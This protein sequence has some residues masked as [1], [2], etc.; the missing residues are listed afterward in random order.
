MNVCPTKLLIYHSESNG[1]T[2]IIESS[3]IIYSSPKIKMEYTGNTQIIAD[4]FV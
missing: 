4:I 1:L 3:E 2:I